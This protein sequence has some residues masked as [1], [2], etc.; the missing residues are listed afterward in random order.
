MRLQQI[1]SIGLTAAFLLTNFSSA[2]LAAGET[3]QLRVV[4]TIDNTAGGNLTA[5]DIPYQFSGQPVQEG[6]WNTFLATVYLLELNDPAGFASRI[7]TGSGSA[8]GTCYGTGYVD[9]GA[10][11]MITCFIDYVSA[12]NWVTVTSNVTNDNNGTAVAAD[13]PLTGNGI[14]LISGKSKYFGLGDVT[15]ATTSTV[16]GYTTA[17]G[18][19]CD[20]T[21][22]TTLTT[23]S[24]SICTVTFDDIAPSSTGSLIV[25]TQV[26]NDNTG[27]K[28]AT[29]FAT[30]LNK[31]DGTQASFPGSLEGTTIPVDAGDYSVTQD[32]TGYI[33]TLSAEC[34]GSIAI[35]ETKTCTITNNDIP[36]SSSNG[37]SSGGGSTGGSGGGAT[38]ADSGL[39]T[40]PAPSTINEPIIVLPTPPTAPITPPRVLGESFVEI[41]STCLT[42]EPDA[43]YITA[44]PDDLIR[45]LGLTQDPSLQA[46]MLYALVQ[47]IIVPDAVNNDTHA[48]V[49]NFTSIG[50]RTSLRLGAGERAGVVD[51]FKAIY[52]RLPANECDWQEA[53]RIANHKKPQTLNA[54]R[55]ASSIQLFAKIYK[56]EAQLSD[57]EDRNA[58]DIMAYG[59][60]P[61]VRS[62][63][64]EKKAIR[65]F[66]QIMKHGPG[67]A[68]EWDAIRAIA[69]SGVAL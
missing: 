44:N 37:G 30:T 40:P 57:A 54:R 6:V 58:I 61:L 31:P 52:G 22:K 47:K 33:Q 42:D 15:I 17:F 56:R 67:N 19:D 66:A 46:Q 25:I 39:P 1:A 41:S 38:T 62:L 16:T 27:T 34:S 10:D 36:F 68:T 49:S 23:G 24:N 35:S 43:A 50:T 2:A 3:G 11:E 64:E 65:I 8:T 26:T 29:D 20:E 53:L 4:V 12:P 13:F 32:A 14:S 18:G 60:R 45:N 63:N 69:Y 5:N 55:E 9:L 48:A 28:T 21:G 59:I 51:S 7:V